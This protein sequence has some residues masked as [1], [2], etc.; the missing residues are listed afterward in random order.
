MP[1]TIDS[2]RR[3]ENAGVVLLGVSEKISIDKKVE[4][5]TKRHVTH[6]CSFPVTSGLSVN[7]RVLKD[8]LQPCFYGFFLISI[9]HIIVAM[10]IKWP[11]KRIMIGKTDFYAAYRRFHTNAHIAVTCIAIVV[12]LSFLCLCLLF[13][14]TTAQAEYTTI[15]EAEIYLGNDLLADTSWDATNLQLPHWHLLLR[16]D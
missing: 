10:R 8:T 7:N 2:L 6:N 16:E 12:K 9:L 4:R 15:S 13:G 11:S 3:I 14:T 5:Y 1:L